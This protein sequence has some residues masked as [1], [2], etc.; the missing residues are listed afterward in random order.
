MK[1]PSHRDLPFTQNA[2]ERGAILRILEPLN[3]G[4]KQ[5]K[6]RI[7][8]EEEGKI[9]ARCIARGRVLFHLVAWLPIYTWT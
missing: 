5:K 8:D 6:F 3:L 4:G 7:L 2:M 9:H 1:Q